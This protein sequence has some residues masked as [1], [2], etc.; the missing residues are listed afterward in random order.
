VEIAKRCGRN[1]VKSWKRGSDI[2]ICGVM[3]NFQFGDRNNNET[4]E[5]VAMVETL[6]NQEDLQVWWK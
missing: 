1:Y 5:F 4:H 3:R 2:R 6:K